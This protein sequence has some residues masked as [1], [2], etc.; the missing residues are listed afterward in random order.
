[1][2]QADNLARRDETR[3][4]HFSRGG[5][6]ARLPVPPLTIADS[7]FPVPSAPY[8]LPST[9]DEILRV[10]FSLNK[11]SFAILTLRKMPTRTL[12]RWSDHRYCDMLDLTRARAMVNASS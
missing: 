1:M 6:S 5:F 12:Q 11:A 10:V 8:L 7:I 4:R 9:T 3:T 2:E